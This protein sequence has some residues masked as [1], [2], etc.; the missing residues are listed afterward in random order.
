MERSRELEQLETREHQVAQAED[1]VGA[2][3]AGVEEEMNRRVAKVRVDLEGRYDLKLKLAGVE[4][5]GRAA[6]LRPRLYEAERRTEATAAALVTAQSDLASAR[7][8]LRSRRR[9]VD[10]AEA[11]VRENT[12]E[13]LQRRTLER[14]HAPMLQD[15]R[16]RANIALGHICDVEAPT[17]HSNDYAS[18]LTFFTEVVTRLEA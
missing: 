12:E 18:H 1:A 11:V 14:E 8:E 2:R 5:E 6:A 9:R 4:D 15:L 7:T 16:N 13:V 17:P 10:D 3:G